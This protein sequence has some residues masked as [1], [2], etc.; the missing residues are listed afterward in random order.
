M[1]NTAMLAKLKL[2][3]SA[4]ALVLAA[5]ACGGSSTP[6]SNAPSTA[7]DPEPAGQNGAANAANA[8]PN[9]ASG[10]SG[11]SDTGSPAPGSSS[12]ND[13]P[14]TSADPSTLGTTSGSSAST[15]G[16]ADSSALNDAQ[17]AAITDHVNSAEIEQGQLAQ[18]KSKN[19]RVKKFAKM[20]IDHHGQ[21][22]K[23]QSKLNLSEA[24]TPMSQQLVSEA[25]ATLATLKEKS[26]SDFDKAYIQAQID[27]HQKVLDA[28]ERDLLPNAKDPQL[29]A[30]L[31]NLKPKVEQHLEQAQ[32]AQK[33][34]ESSAQKSGTSSGRTASKSKP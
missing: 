12:V 10:T 33:A 34:I 28:L 1:E 21:A 25:E 8:E 14:S 7:N 27:G 26:G 20:M 32:A 22:K 24:E 19:E 15:A 18:T 9:S 16:A 3:V 5:A 13:T 11:R 2:F 31:E 4:H 23:Q 6:S 17:I 29:K 30:Y